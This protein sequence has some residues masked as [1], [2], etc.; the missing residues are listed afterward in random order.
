MNSPKNIS[1]FVSLMLVAAL[2]F[3]TTAPG[4]RSAGETSSRRFS[5]SSSLFE[6]QALSTAALKFCKPL[7]RLAG[8]G[9]LQREIALAH[10]GETAEN[11]TQPDVPRGSTYDFFLA[12]RGY[13]AA[14]AL[15]GI[16]VGLALSAILISFMH[17]S[18]TISLELC[19]I[20]VLSGLIAGLIIFQR[21]RMHVFN[22]Y[23][24]ALLYLFITGQT[25]NPISRQSHRI[26]FA[27]GS[28]Q[29]DLELEPS[30]TPDLNLIQ[31]LKIFQ[32]APE[33]TIKFIS[34]YLRQMTSRDLEILQRQLEN[35][36]QEI[37]DCLTHHW[38]VE[39]DASLRHL[40]SAQPTS[41]KFAKLYTDKFLGMLR[42]QIAGVSSRKIPGAAAGPMSFFHGPEWY[43]KYIAPQWESPLFATIVAGLPAWGLLKTMHLAGLTASHAPAFILAF[44]G[45]MLVVALFGHGMS[46]LNRM[47]HAKLRRNV[48]DAPVRL[49]WDSF[50]S[51]LG[52][53][54]LFLI[55]NLAGIPDLSGLLFGTALIYALVHTWMHLD[56]NIT[57]P[58]HERMSLMPAADGSGRKFMAQT[59]DGIGLTIAV[60]NVVEAIQR[61]ADE[62]GLPIA[63]VGGTARRMALGIKPAPSTSDLDLAVT[64]ADSATA[65]ALHD[66]LRHFENQVA[67]QFPRLTIDILNKGKLDPLN[68]RGFVRAGPP[69]QKFEFTRCWTVS[70]LLVSRRESGWWVT[71]EAD[72][73]YLPD[74]RN[75]VFRLGQTS[76]N[77]DPS[78]LLHL[79]KIQMESPE[80]RVEQGSRGFVNDYLRRFFPLSLKDEDQYFF[81]KGICKLFLRSSGAYDVVSTM[82]AVGPPERTLA[83]VCDEIV[84]L[85][86]AQGISQ[87]GVG[88]N[89]KIFLLADRTGLMKRLHSI[90]RQ[91]GMSAFLLWS[92]HLLH[93]IGSV[94][95]APSTTWVLAAVLLTATGLPFLVRNI[96]QWMLGSGFHQGF[97][98]LRRAA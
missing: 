38:Q 8:L 47:L 18:N 20:C 10:D 77:M 17:A 86:M 85:D 60:D 83:D 78:M 93:G 46:V 88:W 48:G 66:A 89:L 16:L 9:E 95:E 21:A 36:P 96:G 91:A 81:F 19:S 24:N 14:C 98:R 13:T 29:I 42:R 30:F 58:S 56:H 80:F 35:L 59:P 55:L 57:S 4:N 39:L 94:R 3:Q 53:G 72:G 90:A 70:R 40:R 45:Y 22:G 27:M 84:D 7:N 61:I 28:L 76:L 52:A 82:K 25:A 11:R 33:L 79:I 71:D 92:P 97:H 12:S 37:R 67:I 68:T 74:I 63:F 51:A 1:K 23:M 5:G 54:V 43:E 69:Y 50:R 31:F 6:E 15:S 34:K 73:A 87:I 49:H 44:A 64:A 26:S 32:E 65:D 62:C 2:V 41:F 75:L